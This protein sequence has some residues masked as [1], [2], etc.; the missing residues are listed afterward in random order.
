MISVQTQNNDKSNKIMKPKMQIVFKKVILKVRVFIVKRKKV[1]NNLSQYSNVEWRNSRVA[2]VS[3]KKLNSQRNN[4]IW[5]NYNTDKLPFKGS[6]LTL[7]LII[8]WSTTH[9]LLT[10][11]FCCWLLRIYLHLNWR[12]L[13]A[14]GIQFDSV[15]ISTGR[16]LSRKSNRWFVDD[17]QT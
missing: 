4:I 7:K 16:K 2:D 17:I 12:H 14:Q 9:W 6:L 13:V 11:Y 5:I 10:R 8:N 3:K 15:Q 1:T